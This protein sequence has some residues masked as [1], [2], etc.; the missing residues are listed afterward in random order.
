MNSL[1]STNISNLTAFVGGF[2]SFFSPCIL[3]IIPGFVAY[4]IVPE[5]KKI[6]SS[7]I[8]AIAFV[9]GLSFVFVNLGVLSGYLGGFLTSKKIYLNIIGGT[10]VILFGLYIMKI[11][12][13][14]FLNSMSISP[15]TKSKKTFLSTFLLG[16]IFSIVWSPCLSP[17]LGTILLISSQTGRGIQGGILLTFYSI[18]FAIPFLLSAILIERFSSHIAKIQKYQK[19]I[20]IITGIILIVIGVL[21]VTNLFDKIFV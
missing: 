1:V 10:M 4:F 12:D 17:T 18:G 15:T 13:I 14:P 2:L 19:T 6:S 8:N 3:P 16:L 21:M 7:L 5:E 20:E 9:L 11:I